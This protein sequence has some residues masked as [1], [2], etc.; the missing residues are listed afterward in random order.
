[1]G[2][3]VSM[4][5]AVA[6]AGVLAGCRSVVPSVAVDGG[7]DA[8]GEPVDAPPVAVAITAALSSSRFVVREHMLAAGEM[9]ISGE[10]LAQAM[11]RDLA[12]YS[13]DMIPTDVYTD[14]NTHFSWIDLP[15]F[16]S[17]VESYEYS[18][19]PMNE[20]AFETG[21]GTAL[22]ASPLVGSD[23]QLAAFVQQYA[24]ESNALGKWVFPAGTFPIG[25][26]FGDDN[27][28]GTG[29]PAENPIGWPGL[30]PT[31]HVF[32]DYD[33][34]LAPT[35][36]VDLQCSISSDDNPHE[37]A[38]PTICS[39]FEC[40]ATTLHLPDR[41]A[42]I[43]PMITP[44]ADGFATWK[45][46]LW[47]INYLQIMHDS[48]ENPV[49]SVAPGDLAAV[50]TPDNQI[51]G[52]DSTGAATA[53]GTFVGSSDIE[54]FQAAM[55]LQIIDGRA[56][57]WLGALTTSDGVTLSGFS[58]VL[59]ADAYDYAGPLRWFPGAIAVTETGGA[60]VFPVPAYALAS[61]NSALLDQ[62]GLAMGFAEIYALTDQHNPDVGGSQPALAYFDGDP[63]PAD[64]QLA[65]G[66][67]T[68]HD[69]ALA[70]VRVAIV[71]ADRLHGD[72]ATGILVDD[73][74][75]TGTTPSRGTTVATTT[76]AYTLIGLRTVRRAL[77]SELELYSNNT[78]D[79]TGVTTPLD[80]LAINYPGNSTLTFS[81]RVDQLVLA[82]AGLLYNQLTD[83]SGRA[84]S[85]GTSPRTRRPA[86][87][88]RSTRTRRR[89]AGCLPRTWRPAMCAIATARSRCS[90]ASRPRST[91][92][93]QRSTARRPP[94]SQRS[95]TRRC[96]S[97]CCKARC[98][99]STN[100]SRRHPAARRSSQSWRIGSPG[101]TSSCSTA[102][103]IATTIAS[104]IGPTN[105]CASSMDYRAAGCRWPSAHCPA[106]SVAST[107]KAAAPARRRP[108]A[109]TTACRRSTLRRPRQ[110]SP[111]RSR[112]R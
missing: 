51:I 34:T 33:P 19:Q 2:V 48:L 79:T 9:Q 60:G 77:S 35:S 87:T 52:S 45:Y 5:I 4:R 62:I 40:D 29:A 20:L 63:F 31:L 68:L 66:E 96:A 102:G 22:S 53:P 85:A 59:A 50:G 41:A 12:A 16:S 110:R 67:S 23:A 80:A 30:W 64:D 37:S 24:G 57:D 61:P 89:S 38:N 74:A 15:G 100:W 104:S 11:G 54:G 27:P 111:T 10:P 108:T 82:H 76:V 88:T 75:M 93:W 17:G 92:R 94:R 8:P 65:D 26:G 44:G 71:N 42:Q 3:R 55:L 91:T 95:S 105:A 99:T 73:V 7:V 43:D 56:A 39:D 69:R 18:K 14:P 36:A 78:P 46:A 25:N 49:A 32:A 112:S 13:R 21:A 84:W 86:M 1:M 58:N 101:S 81:A 90:I 47:S 98:A 72:P 83:A 97:H 109:S 28:D 6:I 107:T 70:M 103:T 106:R